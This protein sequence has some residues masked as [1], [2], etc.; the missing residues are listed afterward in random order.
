MVPGSSDGDFGEGGYLVG[1][2][3]MGL[4]TS[5]MGDR[6]LVGISGILVGAGWH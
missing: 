5:G 1:D 2:S 4:V 3:G 6:D